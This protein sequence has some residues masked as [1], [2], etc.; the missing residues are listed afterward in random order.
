MT[1]YGLVVL[2]SMERLERIGKSERLQPITVTNKDYRDVEIAP[3]SVAYCDIPYDT[4][5]G[6]H[7][8][9]EFDHA[10]FWEWA[11]TR[12]FP[13]YVSEYSGPE[14]FEAVWEKEIVCGMTR[15]KGEGGG[16]YRTE[17]LFWNGVKNEK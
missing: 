11:R 14:D 1:L 3:D 13:V 9:A 12:D 10:A 7:Y 4:K 17:K 16:I 6:G 2:Q 15:K 8:G 5:D